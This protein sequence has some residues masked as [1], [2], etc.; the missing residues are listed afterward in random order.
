MQYCAPAGKVLYEKVAELCP[1]HPGRFEKA[2]AQAVQ[3]KQI[4]AASSSAASS[5]KQ[6]GK[7]GKKKRK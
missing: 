6:A 1:R 5:S 3:A 2:K 4:A 7:S